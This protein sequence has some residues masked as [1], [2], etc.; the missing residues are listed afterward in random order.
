[1]RHLVLTPCVSISDLVRKLSFKTFSDEF[2]KP[3]KVLQI[4]CRSDHEK[5]GVVNVTRPFTFEI[6]GGGGDLKN[7][8]TKGHGWVN[9]QHSTSCHI[10]SR[11]SLTNHARIT[12][13]HLR[14]SRTSRVPVKK[15]TSKCVTKKRNKNA[16]MRLSTVGVLGKVVHTQFF[17]G[18][19]G[20]LTE[21]SNTHGDV[22]AIFGWTFWDGVYCAEE[23][24]KSFLTKPSKLIF[25]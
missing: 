10:W 12:P 14:R 8:G 15:Q 25:V 16:K 3:V 6:W 7:Q 23:K 13:T 17:I 11:Y 22:N 1:M 19:S 4:H 5:N 24:Q 20:L 2:N 9:T 21:L 18:L